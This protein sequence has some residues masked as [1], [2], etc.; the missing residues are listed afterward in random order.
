MPLFDKKQFDSIR[1]E[2]QASNTTSKVAIT[3]SKSIKMEEISLEGMTLSL[4]ARSCAQGHHLKVELRV[5]R[6]IQTESFSATALVQE[7]ISAQ[8]ED[9]VKL[10]LL[11][12]NR[13]DLE[14]VLNFITSEGQQVYSLFKQMKGIE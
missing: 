9:L 6:G 2:I 13:D 10:K 11:Q 7:V 4:P 14:K 5:L 1:F 12:F 8:S 3:Q